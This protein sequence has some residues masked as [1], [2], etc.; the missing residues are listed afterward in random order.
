MSRD[1]ELE[2]QIDAYIKGKLTEEEAQRLWEELLKNPEYIELLNTELGIKSILA[3]QSASNSDDDAND[4]VEE[5]GIVY[6]IRKYKSWIAAAA[7]VAILVVAVNFLQFDNTKNITAAFEDINPREN[8]SSA[9]IM[10]SQKAGLTPADSLL[11]KGF[12]AAVAGDLNKALQTYNQIIE[13]YGDHPAAVQAFLNKGIIQYNSGDFKKAI[14]SFN[15]V[16][17]NVEDKQVVKEKAFWYLG[18]AYI[19]TDSLDEAR[20]AIHDAYA[21]DGIYRKPAFRL[22]RKLDYEL[23]N[24]D[25][26]NFEQQMKNN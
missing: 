17:D 20:D 9:Q 21:M 13:K 3:E 18:N 11:N 7:S 6:S 22:L 5:A 4:D 14:V 25:F 19:N 23:G 12:E 16:L 24:I 26:D 15:S 2:Q 10:R 1:L 8:L